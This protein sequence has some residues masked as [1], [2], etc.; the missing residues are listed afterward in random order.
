M[1]IIQN[2]VTGPVVGQPISPNFSQQF[3]G[4][5][6]VGAPLVQIPPTMTQLEAYSRGIVPA[7]VNISAVN[8]LSTGTGDPCSALE[9]MSNGNG[10][11]TMRGA[12]AAPSGGLNDQQFVVGTSAATFASNGPTPTNTDPQPLAPVS[13][14]VTGANVT[15][16]S[17][18]YNG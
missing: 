13:G 6:A 12:P 5:Q 17:N 14:A 15:L 1:S 11:P 4:A 7:N 16:A 10:P 9:L 2:P 3:A 18:T 8:G